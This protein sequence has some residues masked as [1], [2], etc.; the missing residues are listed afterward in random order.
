MAKIKEALFREEILAEIEDNKVM[1]EQ[2]KIR[3]LTN[4]EGWGIIYGKFT[5]KVLSLQ[6]AFD[7]EDKDPQAMLIDLQ[8]RKIASNTLFDFI[9]EI[10]GISTQAKENKPIDNKG[11][12]INL[13][14]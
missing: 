3:S 9:R 14:N 1:S 11:Y 8:A 13:D 7:I 2:E 5:E 10:Q 4:H 12:I 6:N